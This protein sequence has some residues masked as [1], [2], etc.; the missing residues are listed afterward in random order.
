MDHGGQ[1]HFPSDDSG[2]SGEPHG[3]EGKAEE[4]KIPEITEHLFRQEA[5][6]LV[7]V[8]TGIFGIHRLQ[9]AEDVVQ[10]ALVRALRTWPY[11]GVPDNPTAWLMRTAKNRALD[12]LRR[13]QLF[14][15]KQEEI[16]A[17]LE[18]LP[19]EG[20]RFDDEI[21]D[22]RLRL[23]FACCH[24][25]ISLE[26]QTVLALRTLCGFGVPEIASAFLSGESA[27]AKRLVRAKQRIQEQG[28]GFEIPSGQ[29]L[30]G[31]LDGVLRVLYLLF[32][33]GY[34]SS[35]GDQ[36]VRADLCDEAI[37]L[38]ALLA[39]HPATGHPRVHALLALMLLHASR[40]P[41]RTDE[42]GGVLTLD[43]QDRLKWDATMIARGLH[44]L[45]QAAAGEPSDYHFQAGI[46]ALHATARSGEETD[47]PRILA[48]YDAWVARATSPVVALNRAVA[49]SK[50]HGP[51]AGLDALNSIPHREALTGYHLFHAVLGDFEERLGRREQAASRYET[52]LRHAPGPAERNFLI[53]CLRRCREAAG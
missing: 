11:Y 13:E 49:V 48:H 6:K 7:S 2:S 30:P 25:S 18:Q 5:G 17:S 50:V 31:R 3:G 43:S 52:A 24:P 33:E 1:I 34:K 22:D 47:W 27:V 41:A 26:D 32:N 37:R 44:H 46:A 53:A 8:L 20:V 42:E 36:L 35:T 15:E 9:L 45:T 51:Q 21:R 40:L 38:G 28:L 19:E 39:E 10:E 16:A 4:R 12:L 14:H 29:D 23:I